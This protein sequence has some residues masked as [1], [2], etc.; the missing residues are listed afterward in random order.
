[1]ILEQEEMM[2][3]PMVMMML[4]MK[5]AMLV[6]QLCNLIKEFKFENLE[7]DEPEH[8]GMRAGESEDSS[9]VP[10]DPASGRGVY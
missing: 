1:M 3:Q 10:N 6:Q 5:E 9:G 2:Q 4:P 7:E 8:Y